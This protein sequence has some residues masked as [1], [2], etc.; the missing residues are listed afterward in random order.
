MSLL[1]FSCAS[2]EKGR[3]VWSSQGVNLTIAQCRRNSVAQYLGSKLRSCT[4]WRELCSIHAIHPSN[5]AHAESLNTPPPPSAIAIH[6]PSYP[7]LSTVMFHQ[8]GG[9]TFSTELWRATRSLLDHDDAPSM[10]DPLGRQT[11]GQAGC[12]TCPCRELPPQPC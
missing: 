7:P 10:H 6:L 11:D 3:P 9:E 4:L 2:L 5:K 8:I 12:V 1:P